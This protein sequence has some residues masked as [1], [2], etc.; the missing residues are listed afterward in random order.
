MRTYGQVKTW[1]ATDLEAAV[2]DLV[3]RPTSLRGLQDE[4]EVA[5]RVLLW[6]GQAAEA[7]EPPTTADATSG[8]GGSSLRSLPCAP[9]WTRPATMSTLCAG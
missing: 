1:S 5:N 6:K 2:D 4:L 8:C 3:A 9:P 7:D